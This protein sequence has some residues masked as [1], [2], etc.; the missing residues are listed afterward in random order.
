MHIL[1]YPPPFLTL[2]DFVAI[3]ACCSDKAAANGIACNETCHEP[4]TARQ[5]A[6][7]QKNTRRRLTWPVTVREQTVKQILLWSWQQNATHIVL[8]ARVTV[9]TRH[10]KVQYAA[11]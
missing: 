5:F 8:L 10:M 6:A 1:F 3:H 4:T 7:T 2:D 9:R 11:Q